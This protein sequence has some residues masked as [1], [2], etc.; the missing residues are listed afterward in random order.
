MERYEKQILF[1]GIGE[2]GQELLLQKKVLIIG[3][4]GL[5]TTIA[6]NLTRSGV[7]KIAI[8]DKDIVETSNLQRQILFDEEDVKEKL[9]K[10]IAAKKKLKQIN[11]DIEIEAIVDEI[12]KDNIRKYCSGVDVIL[13]ATDNFETRYLINDTAINLNIPW[14]YG[15]VIGSTGMVHTTLPRV[16]PCLRCIFPKEERKETYDTCHTKGV[17]NSI[18]SIIGS[19]ESNEAIKIL[20]GK[21]DKVIS[22]LQYIDIWTNEFELINFKRNENCNVC[23]KDKDKK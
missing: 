17:L 14:V 2:R 19:I 3:C 22:G 20:L 7:S 10:A 11:S 16:T 23:S 1:S 6:N 12:S 4:G 21:R 9:P 18:T 13:D 15:G 8:I 5:G